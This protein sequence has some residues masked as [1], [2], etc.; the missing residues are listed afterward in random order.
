MKI[1]ELRD[2]VTIQENILTPDGY[3]GFSEVW[4]DKYT[5]WANIKPLR[6]REYFEMKKVQSEITHKITIR[7]RNDINTSNRIKYKGQIFYIK[8]IIDIDNRHRFLEIMCIGSG[9][10]G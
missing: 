4:Q 8:S 10:D 1:G 3:G 7:F 9:E 5:V 6:G 2:R